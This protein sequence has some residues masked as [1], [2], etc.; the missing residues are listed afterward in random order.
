M[1]ELLKPAVFVLLSWLGLFFVFS[2]VG[3]LGFRCV[4]R[5][6]E[7]VPFPRRMFLAF[8]VGWALTLAV[9]QIWHVFFAVNWVALTFVWLLGLAGLGLHWRDV[10][11]LLQAE[12]RENGRVWLAVAVLG[13]WF[14]NLATAG[15]TNYDDSLYRIQS[16]LWAK[17]YPIVPGLGN[18]HGRLAFN[19][20]YYLYA[21]M[22]DA[23]EWTGRALHLAGGLL[24]TVLMAH[25]VR[26]MAALF[27]GR[28]HGR[29][30]R[31]FY[32]LLL[33]PLVVE[34]SGGNIATLAPSVPIFVLASILLGELVGFL[35]RVDEMAS[36][37][38]RLW[39]LWFALIAC[40]GIVVERSFAVFG[41]AVFVVALAIW[42]AR[43]PRP[44][45]REALGTLAWGCVPF[46]LLIAPWMARG[47]ILSG[48]PVYPNV[49]GGVNVPWRVPRALVISEANWLRSWVRTPQVFW[50]D[51][52]A[53]MSWVR[54]WADSLPAD[55][56]RAVGV[57]F[58]AGLAGLLAPGFAGPARR[59]RLWPILLPPI[60]ALV[61]W[62]LT[63]PN[64]R[65]A[66]GAFWGLAAGALTA[67]AARFVGG[68][69]ATGES[70]AEG[71]RQSGF[72]LLVVLAFFLFLSPI[73]PPYLV[74]PGSDAGFSPMPS[75]AYEGRVTNAGFVVYVPKEGD[76]C[77]SAPLPCAHSFRPNLGSVVVAGRYGFMLD[78]S[79]RY[80]DI[81]GTV[82]SPIAEG[83]SAIYQSGW[84]YPDPGTGIQWMRETS[85]ILM[86]AE[87]PTT[88]YVSLTPVSMHTKGRFGYSGRLR[89]LVNGKEVG[90]F[91][92]RKDVFTEVALPLARDF[93]LVTFQYLG[94]SFVPKGSVPGSMDER[95]LGIGFYPLQFRVGAQ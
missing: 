16:M 4:R 60:A 5:P 32:A 29:A 52:L 73:R 27:G 79:I 2:G 54:K 84:H 77:G 83:V 68:A 72:L 49:F 85:R 30:Y 25:S 89:V 58:V 10:W 87:K 3:L 81:N 14:G 69:D 67:T 90:T 18:V 44:A 9:L 12:W 70:D 41:I 36:A 61:A 19:S 57:A 48:Y 71:R 55:V 95:V 80:L 21:A 20:T 37:E 93:N 82:G 88:L 1:L 15:T 28:G 62:F 26:S 65:L 39:L 17:S 24:A 74:A 53:D 33:A 35:V 59:K 64:P 22:L 78:D 11:A 66:M 43:R 45:W 92:M 51:V 94:G 50:G 47:I 42:L 46:A 6:A 76:R 23:G 91:D 40:A 63:V 56:P 7:S 86:Y 13:L 34:I 8:W 38:V 31:L 75:P